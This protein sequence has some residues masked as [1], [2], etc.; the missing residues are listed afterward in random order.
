M[1]ISFLG[2]IF[3][4]LVW[5]MCTDTEVKIHTSCTTS[6]VALMAGSKLS[7]DGGFKP[8]EYREVHPRDQSGLGAALDQPLELKLPWIHHPRTPQILEPES[9][10]LAV[11]ALG[12]DKIVSP[13]PLDLVCWGFY[14]IFLPSNQTNRHFWLMNT[15]P[16]GLVCWLN[17][18]RLLSW[19]CFA[20]D[21]IWAQK[22]R[23]IHVLSGQD[24]WSPTLSC[25]YT[26][27]ISEWPSYLQMYDKT[28]K[29]GEHIQN[30]WGNYI[31]S[32]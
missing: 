10:I 6:T 3:C 29:T 32:A 27:Q 21:F 7:S 14:F 24:P 30:T 17:K 8:S 5:Y 13:M 20:W 23:S 18:G 1:I 19:N 22:P 28:S 2:S 12:V 25:S 9:T 4:L 31:Q 26:Q 11:M 15:F 16:D